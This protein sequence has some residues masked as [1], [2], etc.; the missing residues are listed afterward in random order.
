MEK[1]TP[2][3]HPGTFLVASH[4]CVTETTLFWLKGPGVRAASEGT[5]TASETQ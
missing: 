2:V 1:L 4:Y 5:E 3:S